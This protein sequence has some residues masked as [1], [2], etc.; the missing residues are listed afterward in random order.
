LAAIFGGDGAAYR[1][2]HRIRLLAIKM[3]SPAQDF[4]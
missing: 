1:A 4:D 2:R 3:V